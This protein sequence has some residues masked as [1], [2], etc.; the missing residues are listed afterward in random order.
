VSISKQ[1]G[2]S[3]SD[4]NE[5]GENQAVDSAEPIIN[6]STYRFVHLDNLVE[7]QADMR[8]DFAQFGLK[9]TVL[10]ADEGINA[11]LA[12][13]AGQIQAAREWFAKDPRFANLWLKE[14]ESQ[15]LPFSKL[16]IKIRNEIIAFQPDADNPV[17][18]AR[19]PAPAMNPETLKQMLDDQTPFTLLDT[20]NSYEIDSGTFD[21]AIDLKLNTFKEFA[22]AVDTAL[23]RGDLNRDKPVVTFCTGGIRCEKAAPYLI[24]QG[25]KE[26]YQIEGGILNYFEKC[27]GAHWEGECFVF[28]DRVEINSALQPTGASMCRNCHRAVP[29][30]DTCECKS[31]NP[32]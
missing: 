14:S 3:Q 22:N 17:S 8:R 23:D 25:F 19:N 9:G 27:G 2:A 26:V 10:L 1:N 32:W 30:N 11:A 29:I 4:A 28:D 21:Q 12:G 6:V 20:R 31:P 15:I 24:E 7:L 5:P 18:P 13:T 16:K